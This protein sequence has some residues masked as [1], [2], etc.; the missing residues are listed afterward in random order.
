MQ[1]YFVDGSPLIPMVTPMQDD[2]LFTVRKAAVVET[3]K[4]IVL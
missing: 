3:K 1:P 2:F 4:T